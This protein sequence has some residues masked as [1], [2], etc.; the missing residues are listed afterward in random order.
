[1]II[2]AGRTKR[3]FFRCLIFYCAALIRS[4][5][6][7]GVERSGELW[8]ACDPR[9]SVLPYNTGSLLAEDIALLPSH[10]AMAAY[11]DT[12]ERIAAPQLQLARTGVRR[13]GAV[14]HP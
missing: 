10:P 2:F 7:P 3:S 5:Q 1:M 12:Y 4:A 8:G 6:A 14:Y 9:L 11:F 13:R